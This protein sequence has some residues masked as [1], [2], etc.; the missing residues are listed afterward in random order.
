MSQVS[1][2]SRR[3][4]AAIGAL[5]ALAIG[6]LA[7][8]RGI[9]E[10]P[11]AILVAVLALLAAIG[12][13]WVALTRTGPDRERAAW[14][15]FGLLAVALIA[16]VG[17]H[18]EGWIIIL[19]GF[20]IAVSLPLGRYALGRDRRALAEMTPPGEVVAAATAPVLLIN[21]LSGDGKAAR[22]D[23]QKRAEDRGITCH[24]FGPGVDLGALASRCISEGADVIG[25]AG[26]DG[27]QAIVADLVRQAGLA[28]VVIPSGTRNHFAMDLGLDR[29][30]PAS[31]LD[32]FGPARRKTVDMA[33]V[34]GTAFLNNASM[35]I[36]GE[37]VQR[38]TYRERKLETTIEQLP[39]LVSAPPELRFT[40]PDG[41]SHSTSQVILVSN[42]PYL[43]DVRGAG[44]RPKL[45]TGVLGIV[46]AEV[47][48]AA[49]VTEMFA[50]AALG[51]LASAPGFNSWTA[52]SFTVTSDAPI[53][54]GIDGEAAELTS[55][56]VF[57]I[58][59]AALNVRIPLTA[60]GRS[61]AAFVPDIRQ[62]FVELFRR[63]FLPV[64]DWQPL[65]RR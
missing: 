3:R 16:A 35:G 60:I 15:T 22:L 20:S 57:E 49:G 44:G 24:T 30:D 23:L 7:L 46:T 54:I 42:N 40:G 12:A 61:P 58:L 39:T 50:R 36:Y 34:N 51:A 6:V 48:S 31:G 65:P 64:Q 45:N 47:T 2:A 8:G 10:N 41:T 56:A 19:G 27:S 32:A 5:V 62:A 14:L 4:L 13:G 11:I 63:A 29:A 53:A 37:V 52:T 59:P 25:V 17:A 1:F 28:L 21:P 33:R 26:G 38:A 9:A 43:L 55:P 18:S